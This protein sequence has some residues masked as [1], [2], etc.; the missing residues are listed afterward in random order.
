MKKLILLMLTFV[1]AMTVMADNVTPEQAQ[2]LASKFLQ[3]REATGSRVR[4]APGT[5][6]QQLTMVPMMKGL[7]VFNVSDDGG[8]IIVSGDDRT[9]S[10]LG[11]S[12]S[13]N[14]DASSM[15]DNMRAWLQGYADEIAWLEQNAATITYAPAKAKAISRVGSHSTAAISPLV[16]T[17]WNQGTPYN[18]LCPNYSTGNRAVTGCVAT[19]MAQVM[20]YHNWPAKPTKTI[21][22]YTTASYGLSL[23]SLTANVTFDWTNMTN[24]YTS[25]ATG[26]TA[27]AVA[28]LMKYCGW[29]VQMD[30]G[31]SSGANSNMVATALKEYFD[32]NSTTTQWVSRSFYTSAKWAD[33][34]YH[35]LANNRPVVYG[36]Q[37]SGGGHEFVCD[38]YKYENGTDFFHIN[39]GWG[40]MSDNYFVLSA[41][42]PDQQG[43]GG[44]SSTDGFHYG[45]DAVI[46][47][48]PST[49]TGAVADIT[50]N[51]I[52]LKLNSMTP[53]I[54]PAFVNMAV[55]ITLNITNNSTDD[56]EGDIYIGRKKSS[57]YSLLAGNNYVI[58][59]GETVDIVIPFTPDEVGTYDLVL[60]LPNNSGS[61]STTGVVQ[62]SLE[63][64]S[65]Y[66]NQF[67]PVYGYYCDD[68]SRSQ[69]IIPA[70][71]LADMCY[72]SLNGVTFYAYT[73]S[74][75]S[76]EDA[77][78]DVY[79]KEVSETTLSELKDWESLQKVY[80]GSLSVGADG[81]MVITFDTPY[82]YKGGN[83]LVGV[84]QT[85]S[86]DY[87]TSKWVG[88]EVNGVSMGG[89]GT[90]ISQQNF[91]PT[92][93]FD[94]TPGE[95]PAKP[96]NVTVSNVGSKAADVSWTGSADS[97]DVRYG[98]VAGNL[99][100]VSSWLQYDN[101]TVS[102]Y[103]GSSTTAQW[104]WGVMYPGSQVT[105]NKLTKLSLYEA[106]DYLE[107]KITVKIYSGGDNAPGTLLYTGI[108]ERG[109]SNGFNEF[110]L[111]SPVEIT[112]G[113]NLWITLT[114]TGTYL[115]PYCDSSEPNNQWIE[116]GG[117]WANI[118]D[119][120]SSFASSGWMIRA[121]MES[122]EINEDA[123]S[124]TT[125]SCNDS[126]CKL[127]GLT[128]ESE[129]IVQVRGNYED[130]SSR[131]ESQT[132][133]TLANVILNDASDN[134]SIIESY[135]G[136]T[137]GVTINGR[138]LYKDGNWN[139]L[140]LPFDA[141]LT[142]D[143]EGATLMELDTE[144]VYNGHS[145]GLNDATLYL[146]FKAAESIVA[147]KPYILKWTNVGDPV[148]NPTF[149]NV[150]M[151]NAQSAEAVSFTGG[152]F[153]GCYSPVALSANDNSKLYLGAGSKLY[154][155]DADMSVGAF[156]AYFELSN[157]NSIRSFILGFGDETTGIDA[158]KDIE[159]EEEA[160]YDISG[161]R[162]PERPAKSGV[163][164]YNKQKVAIK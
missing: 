40:G 83:L 60:F 29:S 78:F 99:K 22:G 106:V 93:T 69:F 107:S 97:Y 116:S 3:T 59:A 68:F 109:S 45:Q 61:Y 128:P 49:S 145:T 147:G 104:T 125:V 46:G 20:K 148:V 137:V 140:C 14:I 122:S 162:L 13:G 54:N 121:C 156:R 139:T 86:G 129:Y 96:E 112:P 76:W 7:Y 58:P 138:T 53:S 92:T 55:N 155:P 77:E 74:A 63:V 149:D 5:A 37:S 42:D 130:G 79:L 38:G 11:Y 72:A 30:Y 71:N 48:Q 143:L 82:K 75:I 9:R 123:V 65:V 50:P 131:W 85:V 133:T 119:L 101:G 160:W 100:D 32:Y 51:T 23:S 56:Y 102:G 110:T 90:T 108:V 158:I 15:P 16:S 98:L 154:W 25:S 41:L 164:I 24:T 10:I 33:L 8:F 152:R 113:E 153:S 95:E 144:G 6:A 64:M 146:Y 81:K 52:S 136:Q 43:I 118:G 88:T 115:I 163:Y 12:D 18:N 34:I 117:S 126:P 150:T 26:T 142:G 21:P 47:I 4:R 87:A 73:S 62:T 103:L 27:T 127:T 19:A 44:S 1:M 35:E 70:A 17:K 84:N 67:V 124:W 66:T 57:S 105:G 161:R 2:A 94:Y 159:S 141:T 114:A 39:W 120:A 157:P 89:Y 80:A 151:G 111:E 28:T 134:S 91:L 132:F 31:P 135:E 36:G